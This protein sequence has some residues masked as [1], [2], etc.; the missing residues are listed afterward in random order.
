M[1]VGASRV[2]QIK[3]L[4][5]STD[6]YLFIFLYF[7]FCFWIVFFF[8]FFGVATHAYYLITRNEQKNQKTD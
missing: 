5:G 8:F 1:G 3:M 2:L 6:F 7:F 4:R